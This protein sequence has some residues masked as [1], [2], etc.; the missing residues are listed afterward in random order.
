M[1]A[2]HRPYSPTKTSDVPPPVLPNHQF[3]RDEAL[4]FLE[5]RAIHDGRAVCYARHAHE[6]FSIGTVTG[7]Q[8]IY[9]N[10]KVRERIAAGAVV[11]MNP[12]D[13]HAC[14]PLGHQPWSYRMLYVDAFWLSRLQHELGFSKNRGLRAFSTRV[15]YSPSL[16]AGLNQLYAILNDERAEQLHKHSAAISFFAEVQRQLDPAPGVPAEANHKLARAAEY[17]DA[18]CTRALKLDEI[19]TAADLSASYLIRAFKQRYGMTPHEYL[20]NRR[21]QFCRARLRRGQAIADLALE[22]GFADQAHF[23]R[24]FKRL[25]AATPG[26][27]R[28]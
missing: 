14:N 22:A 10:G 12:G 4:P 2:T 3:W 23:Q 18:H 27:Y 21:I 11:V 17:I 9:V 26:Q 7:G 5:A 28:G 8:S 15:T 24:A 19:C 1:S 25:V 20:L 13:A 16:Y 6:T